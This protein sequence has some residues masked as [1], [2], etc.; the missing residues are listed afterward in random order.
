MADAP[1]CVGPTV[2]RP[3]DA[4]AENCPVL[5]KERAVLCQQGVASTVEWQLRDS[6]G[7]PIDLTAC[8][9]QADSATSLD[10]EIVKWG[11]EIVVRFTDAVMPTGCFA[12]VNG[13]VTDA[14]NGLVRFNVPAIIYDE[15]NIY[16]VGIGISNLQGQIVYATTGLLSVERGLFGRQDQVYGPPTIQEI[17][18]QL[19]DTV[20]DNTLLAAIE[21][22]DAEIVYSLTR[23]LREFAETPPP[24]TQ[25]Y[26]G[27][28]F[29]WHDAWLKATCANLL[30]IAAETYR[31]NRLATQQGGLTIDDKNKE[32]P[33]LQAAIMLSQEWK[34]FMTRKKLQLNADNSIG[35]IR[36]GYG[37]GY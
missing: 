6:D 31:R 27:K 35:Y 8:T 9:A 2:V 28:N 11:G 17:R 24:I 23:P 29:P 12:Q 33:Y 20:A 16:L 7:N 1:L 32:A 14:V 26:S 18:L 13:T 4:L 15:A 21:Y 37:Y 25:Q 10:P 5:T 3:E 36:S 22:S 30:K 34:E 19:R